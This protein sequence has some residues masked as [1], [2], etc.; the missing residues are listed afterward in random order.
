MTA[1]ILI[2]DDEQSM[3]ELLEA[4]LNSREFE[5]TWFT[6][7][8][9]AFAALKDQHF[10]VVLTDLKMPD[11]DGIQL[12]ERIV[13]NRP[14]I[15]VVVMTAVGS[16]ETAV[17]AIRTG[18]YDFITKPVEMAMLALTLQRAA[19]HRA[20]QEK[21]KILSQ[22]VEESKRFDNIL[23][24]SVPMQNQCSDAKTVRSVIANRGLGNIRFD[25]G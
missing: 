19:K 2:V 11:V 22:A 13:A 15:P 10:D 1:R 21:V 5:T 17:Q 16:L 12:C 24:A 18:A 20:L 6:A 25:H 7:A 3:C 4:D 23:G 14:D 8:E 9:D